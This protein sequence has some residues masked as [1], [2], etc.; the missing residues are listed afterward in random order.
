MSKKSYRIKLCWGLES[1]DCRNL[2][3]PGTDLYQ[4][5]ESILEESGWP[6]CLARNLSREIKP[7]DQFSIS[8]S[9]CPNGCSRPQIAD[10]GLIQASYPEVVVDLCSGC[11]ECVRVCREG[12]INLQNGVAVIN[13]DLCLSCGKCLESCPENALSPSTSGYRVQVGGKLGR[14]PR[15]AEE[16][17][18]ISSRQEVLHIL[19][20]CL[21]LH[22]E[23]YLPGVRFGQ[24]VSEQGVERI[25]AR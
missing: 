17:S 18:C 8:V 9:G 12:A 2:V 7:L 24:V 11:G 3:F 25:D 14:H 16:L 22:Q 10:F 4:G 20:N 1:G 15:L 23:Y 13:S 5:L 19:A 6:E 21:Q